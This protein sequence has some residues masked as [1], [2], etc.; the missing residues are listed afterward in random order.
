M[1][2]TAAGGSVDYNIQVDSAGSYPLGFRV[3]GA[4]G[5]IRVY[6]GGALLGTATATQTAWST[7]ST[8]VA[9]P[10]GTQTIHVVLASNAQHL[11][12]M[13]FVATNGIPSVPSGLSA[14]GAPRRWY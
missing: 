10:A 3:A 7:V 14:A 1:I 5:Q 12:W 2:S 9:L 6:E 8:T 4:T 13:E 11:N